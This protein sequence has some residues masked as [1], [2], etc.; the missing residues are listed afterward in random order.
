ME[1]LCLHILELAENST[2]AGANV[3][4]IRIVEDE[5][6]N[7][8]TIE[9]ADNGRGMSRQQLAEIAQPVDDAAPGDKV[10]LGLPL[11]IRTCRDAGGDVSLS[12]EPGLGTVL[13]GEMQ[14]GHRDR[15][16]LGDLVETMISL[17]MGAPGIDWEFVH[18]KI[19]PFGEPRRTRVDTAE[20]RRR[21]GELPLAH[22]EVIRRVRHDL[23]EQE[24]KL[25]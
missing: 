4:R 12:S 25:G 16:P 11:F 15:K 22:P 6:A 24:A 9:V 14:L 5:P 7:R 1:D 10:Q 21:I 17:I 3:V 8:L 23:R 2:A 18:E 20:V 13:R 19:P